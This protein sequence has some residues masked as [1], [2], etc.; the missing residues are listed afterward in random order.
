MVCM[1]PFISPDIIDGHLMCSGNYPDYRGVL[2]WS[3]Y[4]QLGIIHN[5]AVTVLVY[6]GN[7]SVD[8]DFIRNEDNR[9]KA[10]DKIY[11]K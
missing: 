3:N 8:M 6:V 7:N 10:Q 5:G 11:I 4:Y 1:T 2:H 9:A